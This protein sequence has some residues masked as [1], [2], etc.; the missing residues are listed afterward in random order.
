MKNIIALFAFAVCALVAALPCTAETNTIT[1]PIK[2]PTKAK[3]HLY[4]LM[5]QSNMAGRGEI[6]TED[7]TPHPRVLVLTTNNVWE[8]AVEPITHDRKSGL[9]VGPSLA[10]GK[11]MAEKD[12]SVTIG[13]VPCAIGGTRLNRWQKGADLYERAVKRAQIAMKDG[14]L[15]G[16]L[17]H[18][19]ESD[20]G[21][22]TLANSYGERLYQMIRDL[23]TDLGSTNLPFVAAQIGEFLYTRK[24]NPSPFAKTVNTALAKLPENVPFTACVSSHDLKDKGDNLHFDAASQREMGRRYATEMLQLQKSQQK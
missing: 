22:N 10:F 21:T 14:T 4:L 23:R 13:L 19:G 15:E 16:V 3:L 2:L 17:W 20:S 6:G 7:K 24:D 5:G 9:G 18:Q 11:A 8:T 1:T 12:P